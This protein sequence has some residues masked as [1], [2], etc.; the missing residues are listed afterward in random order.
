MIAESLGTNGNKR[1]VARHK[2]GLS[3]TIFQLFNA[4]L[5]DVLWEEDSDFLD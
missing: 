4:A 5:L 2:G 3:P 1:E